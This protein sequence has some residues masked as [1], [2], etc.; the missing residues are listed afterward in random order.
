MPAMYVYIQQLGTVMQKIECFCS[1]AG[2]FIFFQHNFT[3]KISSKFLIICVWRWWQ[4]W[5]IVWRG[6][7]LTGLNDQK[8]SWMMKTQIFHELKLLQIGQTKDSNTMIFQFNGIHYFSHNVDSMFLQWKI[9]N[10]HCKNILSVQNS[11]DCWKW[12]N[13]PDAIVTKGV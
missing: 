8:R 4:G 3:K 11:E 13:F 12:W 7:R 6:K 9:P 10:M 5:T 1:D 2:M